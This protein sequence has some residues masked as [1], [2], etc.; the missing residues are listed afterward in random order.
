MFGGGV[1]FAFWSCWTLIKRRCKP[2]MWMDQTFSKREK[3]SIWNLIVVWAFSKNLLFWVLEFWDVVFD[4][5]K[6]TSINGEECP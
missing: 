1:G 6:T 5:R 2:K 3:L 4:V